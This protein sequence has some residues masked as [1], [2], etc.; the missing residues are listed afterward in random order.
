MASTSESRG[1][2]MCEGKEGEVI[3]DVRS[4]ICGRERDV[5]GIRGYSGCLHWI[6]K[7]IFYKIAHELAFVF[8]FLLFCQNLI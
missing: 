4:G 7:T 1:C 3:G 5:W 8:Q 2:G 6:F